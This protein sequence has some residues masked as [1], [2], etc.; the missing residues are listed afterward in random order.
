MTTIDRYL[1]EYTCKE[2]QDII[3]EYSG[4]K[5]EYKNGNKYIYIKGGTE[6]KK[7]LINLLLEEGFS[8]NE[9]ETFTIN[10]MCMKL[11]WIILEKHIDKCN[12]RAEE[13]KIKRKQARKQRALDKK[14]EIIIKTLKE[15]KQYVEKDP[16]IFNYNPDKEIYGIIYLVYNKY[17]NKYYVGQTTR[18][19]D[20]R[21]SNGWINAHKRKKSVKED[22][23]KYGKESFEYTKIF[24]VAHN[25]YDLDKLEAYYIEYF[26]SY[27]NGY[28][29][30]R[31]NIFT[32][33]GKI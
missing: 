23:E 17:S 22:L 24:K 4:D 18:G 29:E 32:E 7:E 14:K 2:V 30:T 33:R 21:Y 1:E 13:D 28:N 3:N 9:C 25:Q 8:K 19:F 5:I 10:D 6:N 11:Y 31:G 27:N 16:Q 15:I 12:K 20:I 26:D